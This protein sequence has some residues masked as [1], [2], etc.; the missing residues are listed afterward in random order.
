M[1]GKTKLSSYCIVRDDE[2]LHEIISLKL[3]QKGMT[4]RDAAKYLEVDQSNVRKYLNNRDHAISQQKVLAL[5]AHLGISVDI[6]IK[7]NEQ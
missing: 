6:D 3:R 2:R 1:P 4:F 7:I 5:A